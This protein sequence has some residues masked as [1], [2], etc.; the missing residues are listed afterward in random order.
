MPG[1]TRGTDLN[2]WWRNRAAFR[3]DV[4][5]NVS[6]LRAL[7]NRLS[8][9]AG[10]AQPVMPAPSESV[11]ELTEKTNKL[12]ADL[13]EAKEQIPKHMAAM[14]SDR[15]SLQ[16]IQ[17][18]VRAGASQRVRQEA[19]RAARATHEAANDALL[20]KQKIKKAMAAGT[21]AVVLF[22]VFWY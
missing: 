5:Q 4:A 15:T 14:E 7:Q 18:N 11:E 8:A 10:N 19:E 17:N 3:Q 2:S 13:A 22:L 6:R 16:A 9:A 12:L 1:D 20:R 21:A